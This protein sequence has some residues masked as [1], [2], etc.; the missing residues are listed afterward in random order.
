MPV[1]MIYRDFSFA[2]DFR[3]V[4]WRV[5][6]IFNSLRAACGALVW[7]GIL[8]AVAISSSKSIDLWHVVI[9]PVGMFLLYWLF[10]V[11]LSLVSQWISKIPFV[12][13]FMLALALPVALGDPLVCL[14]KKFAPEVVPVEEPPLFS[15]NAFYWV[16]R[17]REVTFSS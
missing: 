17:G 14:I 7:T 3:S 10:T 5:A 9:L 2:R 12:G 11:P 1:H 6:L 8:L 13:L 16:I 4:D 15:L